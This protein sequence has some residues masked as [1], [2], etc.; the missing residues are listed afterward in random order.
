MCIDGC[1]IWSVCTN[2]HSTPTDLLDSWPFFLL[3]TI[4]PYWNFKEF[5]TKKLKFYLF[6]LIVE[7]VTL[8]LIKRTLKRL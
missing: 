2:K 8:K 4:I 6:L 7:V 3:Q 1:G 5:S